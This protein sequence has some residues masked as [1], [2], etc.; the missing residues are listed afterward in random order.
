MPT[1]TNHKSNE[2]VRVILVGDSMSGK[3]GSMAS[4]VKAGYHLGIVDMDNKLHTLASYVGKECPDKLANIHYI[5]LRDEYSPGP[6]GPV[7]KGQP[8]AFSQA[9]RM[10]EKWKTDDEDLGDPAEWGPSW[11]FVLDSFSRFCD[12]AYD[13]FE[14]IAGRGAKGQDFRA[15]YGA[16]QDACEKVLANLTS[17]GFGT[18]VIVCCH[19]M[20]QT[21][22]DP[23]GA[24][25]VKAYPQG[26][27]QKLS[28]KIPQYF[29]SAVYYFNNSGKRKIRTTSTP[30]LDLANPKPFQME[31]EYSIETGLAEFFAVLQDPPKEATDAKTQNTQVLWQQ[32]RHSNREETPNPQTP[33]QT[34]VTKPQPTNLRRI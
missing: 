2:F 28:P 12:A 29:P 30:L 13:F 17:P 34:Q 21:I 31:K 23:S 1:L 9:V 32:I 15:V 19:L 6:D 20:Y 3:T 8:K 11:I 5:T 24:D 16:A 14:P 33:T 27:G 25:L 22:K 10:M 26:V 18:N 4:L 7:I